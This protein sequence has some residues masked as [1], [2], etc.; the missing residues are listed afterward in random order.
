MISPWWLLLILP[1]VGVAGWWMGQRGSERRGGARISK[2]SATYFRGLNYLLNEQ[3]DK[4]IEVFLQIA[5]RD[6]ET[7]ETQFTLG[8][9]FRRRGEVDRAIRLHQSVISR[10]AS[11]TTRRPAPSSRWARTTCAPAFW[12]ARK[13]CSPTW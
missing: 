11:A 7:L 12:I 1:V 3:Q 13:P 9:L 6:K 2:L 5:E 4:A 8:T 10:P